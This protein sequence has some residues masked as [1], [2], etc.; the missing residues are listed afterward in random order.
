MGRYP[1]HQNVLSCSLPEHPELMKTMSNGFRKHFR[2]CVTIIDCFE[3][4]IDCPSSLL[5]RAQTYFNYKKHNT[6]E[7]LIGIIPHGSI[8]F[9]SKGWGGRV[10]Y[11]TDLLKM[12]LHVPGDMILADRG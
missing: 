10:A 11:W 1:E 5:A 6:I 12:L 3:V 8:A 4:F 7:F 9:I 2:K